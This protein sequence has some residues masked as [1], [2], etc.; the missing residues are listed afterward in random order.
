MTL[1]RKTKGAWVIHTTQKLQ[2]VTNTVDFEELITAGKCGH[3]MSSLASSEEH[4]LDL[5]RVGAL[6]K[7]VGINSKLE[8]PSILQTLENQKL[9]ERDG[10]SVNVFGLTTDGVLEHTADLFDELEP[11]ATQQAALDMSEM[12]TQIPRTNAELSE[13]IGDQFRISKLEVNDLLASCESSEILDCEQVDGA[14]KL[15]F[16]GNVFKGNDITKA[17][18]VLTSLNEVDSRRVKVVADMLRNRG[19]VPVD[20]IE[21]ELGSQTF[22][23][24]MV[25]GFYDVSEV[26]N[27]QEC[28]K[29]VT[30]PSSFNKFGCTY[31]EDAF[32]LAKAFVAS[33]TYGMNRRE[34]GHGRIQMITRLLR[35]LISGAEVG[36]ATAISQ[37]YQVL[38]FKGVI[39]VSPVGNG[40]STMRLLKKEVGE[41]AL[42]IVEDGD[43]SPTSLDLMPSAPLTQFSGPEQNRVMQRKR[44]TKPS[45]KQT[46]ELLMSLR[47]GGVR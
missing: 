15:Y 33:L 7:A 27:Q 11:S 32:D 45:K 34:T 22:Q 41:I 36:P 19:A 30:N 2:G 21:R 3:L 37:D 18:K 10:G 20:E 1:E 24:L 40:M 28:V 17:Y 5:N 12:V 26:A 39:R 29:Y 46:S 38:E 35:K 16:N 44:Q 6:A 42:R 25:I 8:L 47:T 23:K 31:V 14:T 4:T 43:A 13:K 9:I